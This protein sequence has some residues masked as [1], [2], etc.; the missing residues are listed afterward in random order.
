M[1]TTKIAFS[2]SK[3][4]IISFTGKFTTVYLVEIIGTKW[5]YFSSSISS[6]STCVK[7]IE[8]E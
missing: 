1:K 4:L 8:C 6:G 5:K 3:E 2:F 7:A